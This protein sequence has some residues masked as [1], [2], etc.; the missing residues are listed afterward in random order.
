MRS[1]PAKNVSGLNPRLRVRV[2]CSPYMKALLLLVALVL[3]VP[4]NSAPRVQDFEVR[5]TSLYSTLNFICQ[6]TNNACTIDD[7]A[8]SVKVDHII[9]HNIEEDRLLRTVAN[10]YKYKLVR[11]EDRTLLIVPRQ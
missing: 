3:C 4:V 5:D 8:N 9:L 11:V 10:L 6:S 7:S 1:V 2:P